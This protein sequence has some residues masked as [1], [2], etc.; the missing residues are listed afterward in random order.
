MT[1]TRAPSRGSLV[2]GQLFGPDTD[3]WARLMLHEEFASVT[4][5]PLDDDERL[6]APPSS[7]IIRTYGPGQTV[8]RE[9]R[10]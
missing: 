5:C 1:T 7:N 2:C 4:S 3:D 9:L 6:F 8:P 10:E